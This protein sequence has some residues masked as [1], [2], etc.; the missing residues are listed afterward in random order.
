MKLSLVLLG[1]AAGAALVPIWRGAGHTRH[2]GVTFLQLAIDTTKG[3]PG[4]NF[5]HPH[6]LLSEARQRASAAWEDRHGS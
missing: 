6:I 3:V 2:D 4:T 1:L 5:G